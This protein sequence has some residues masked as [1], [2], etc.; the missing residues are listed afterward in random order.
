MANI[1]ILYKKLIFNCTFLCVIF[2]FL[3]L[4]NNE[5]F[6][7][8]KKILILHSYHKGLKWTD[9]EDRGIREILEKVPHAEIFTEFLDTKR[10]FSDEYFALKERA[11][12]FRYSNVNFSLIIT[13]DDDALNFVAK[14][15][16][17]IFNRA[18][19][20]F[21]GINHLDAEREKSIKSFA[22]GL[23]ETFD[24]ENTFKL[25]L[26]LHPETRRIYIINDRTTTG[27]GNRRALS[28]VIPKFA[29]K[30]EFVFLED[31]TFENLLYEVSQISPFRNL[32]FLMTFNRDASGKVISYDKSIE[33]IYGASPVPIYGVWDFFLGKG[34]VGGCLTSGY[35][36]GKKAG[37][38]A[39]KVLDGA[40]VSKIPIIRTGLNQYMFDYKLLF[41]Y[42]I[43]ITKLP[44]GSIIINKPK[45]FYEI[46]KTLVWLGLIIIGLLISI[47][48]I[49]HRN[50]QKQKLLMQ[51]LA[52]SEAKYRNLFETMPNGYYRS[53]PQG[54]FVDA[55]PAFI[56]MLGYESLEELKSIYIPDTIYVT[57]EEREEISSK[58]SE[59]TSVIEIYRLKRKDGKIIW[60]EDHSRYI[61]DEQGNIIYH[62]GICKDI[63]DRKI[64]EEKILELNRTLEEKVQQRT[65]ELKNALNNL[66]ISNY[67][68]KQLNK[69]IALESMRLA[70]LND[71]LLKSEEELRRSNQTKDKFFSIIAHDLRN[72]I[73]ASKNLLETM[74]LFFDE[75]SREDMKRMISAMLEASKRTY[76]MLENLLTWAKT[77]T[78]KIEYKPAVYS[79]Y[80]AVQNNI[81][82]LE[83]LIN[84]KFLRVSNLVPE[85]LYAYFDPNLI[86]TVLRNLINNAIKFSPIEGIINIGGDNNFDDNYVIVFIQDTG[87]GIE[88]GRLEKLFDISTAHSTRGTAGEKG[89][90]LGLLLCK[91]FIEISGG[92]LWAESNVNEG[93]TFYFTLPKNQNFNR[94]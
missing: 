16:D 62:E 72:P 23:T 18:P 36:Q 15:H 42:N 81:K 43:D 78:K 11:L 69:E 73:G 8:N 52:E 49:L 28:K 21:C 70:E 17:S 64:A 61:R 46:N 44:P 56:H 12:K 32:I 50:H 82:L 20:I 93:S 47:I 92:K 7:Q 68:L 19:V 63:T 34:I 35:Y 80:N 39:L 24:I 77:Q 6:S 71:K 66:E 38:I 65:L 58:S 14:H 30:V 48:L 1:A 9:E 13:T 2:V 86:D 45:S 59:F 53:T 29:D 87:V 27:E 60:V 74:N 51:A 40:D 33:S 54:Y 22:T 88:K 25:M 55:N 5:L 89:T 83:P 79:I 26:K 41:K 10:Y 91:E 3:F 31:L 57:P 94:E 67:E 85:D 76:N 37:E 84:E 90:G 75:L 4:I